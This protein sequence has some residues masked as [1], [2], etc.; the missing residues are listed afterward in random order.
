M[1]LPKLNFTKSTRNTNDITVD[2]TNPATSK[3]KKDRRPTAH[4]ALAKRI[5]ALS[6]ALWLTAMGLLT[7]A[8]AEDM[9]RQVEAQT[10]SYVSRFSPNGRARYLDADSAKLP[11]AMEAQSIHIFGDAYGSLDLQQLL[12][13]VRPQTPKKGYGTDDWIYGK[14]DLLYG[15][16]VAEAFY[17]TDDNVILESGNYLSFYYTTHENWANYNIDPIGLSYV[18]L[19]T[20][21]GGVECFRELL[22]DHPNGYSFTEWFLPLIRLTGFFED[23]QFHPTKIERGSYQSWDGPESDLYQMNLAYGRGQLEWDTL[24]EIPLADTSISNDPSSASA[25]P[26]DDPPQPTT[27]TIYAW[28]IESIFF[29]S[30]PLTSQDESFDS[31]TDLLHADG[32]PIGN[33]PQFISYPDYEKENLLESI[34]IHRIPVED[35]YGSCTYGIAV[36]CWPLT[37]AVLRMFPTYLVSLALLA[38]AIWLLLRN[39]HHHLTEPLERLTYSVVNGTT[40]LPNDFWEEPQAMATYIMDSRQTLTD[41]KTELQQTKA[42]LNYAKHAEENRRQLVSNIT[43]ELKTPLAV[44]HSYVEGL[45]TGIA[46]E[47]RDHYLSV[48]QDE[49]QRMDAMVLQMLDL[50]RLEAGKVHLTMESFSLLQ[51]TQTITERFAPMLETKNIALSFADAQNFSVTADEG[52]I[53]QVITNLMSNAVKYTDEGGRIH[54]HITLHDRKARFAIEN[55][56]APLSKEALN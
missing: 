49:T 52:R 38:I 40:V 35:R 41:T 3:R 25:T 17:D 22:R 19:D 46:E 31:L 56:A 50:S 32:T 8:V 15:F 53:E 37:Y 11:G 39:V 2:K 28:N 6:L 4:R 36:R 54:L 55:T 26:A 43:H 20:I 30:D 44:I 45:Q 18:D 33:D 51:L 9:Y 21:E 16:E 42:A 24:L 23:N 13:I 10:Q 29:D 5:I 12:P 47:K 34:I 48:I 1:T 27:E 7:W 14:W